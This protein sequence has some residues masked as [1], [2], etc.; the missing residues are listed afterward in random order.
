MAITARTATITVTN[1]NDS[2]PGS[3][4]FIGDYSGIASISGV[5]IPVSTDIMSGG[6]QKA[7]VARGVYPPGSAPTPTATP[8][9]SVGS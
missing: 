7:Y 6:N 2:G 4:T 8:C 5:I 9:G 3:S 1:T